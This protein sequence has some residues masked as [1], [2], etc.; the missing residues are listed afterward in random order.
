MDPH[1]LRALT[2]GV[3]GC[4]AAGRRAERLGSKRIWTHARMYARTHAY[5]AYD[6][7]C[8]GRLTWGARRTWGGMQNRIEIDVACVHQARPRA[9]HYSPGPSSTTE[10]WR[11]LGRGRRRRRPVGPRSCFVFERRRRPSA[12][13]SGVVGE[14]CGATATAGLRWRR[15]HIVCLLG[16][17]IV[18]LQ[19]ARQCSCKHGD[20]VRPLR[21]DPTCDV[22]G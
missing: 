5:S 18:A 2:D 16:T 8:C 6:D 21:P 17:C 10:G 9:R 14:M 13:C 1:K 4:V 19:H 12:V 20:W 22:E 11:R 15:L 3:K 7:S